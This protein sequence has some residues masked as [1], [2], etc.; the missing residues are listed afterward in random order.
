AIRRVLDWLRS[1]GLVSSDGPGAV[2]HRIVHGAD[3]FDQSVLIDDEVMKIIE[4][5]GDLA[6]LHN[7]PSLAAIRAAQEALGSSVPMVGVFDTAFHQTIPDHAA[8]YAIPKE[9]TDKYGIRRYGFHGT[10]HRYMTERYAAITDIPVEQARLV[11]L[12]LGNGCSATAV[13]EGC[14]VDTSMG[15]T[16]LEGLIMGTRSGSVDPSLVAFL[17]QHEK[18]DVAEVEN[19]L[20]KESGLLGVSGVSQAMRELLEAEARG[21][22]R[23]ALALKMFCYRVRTYI[24]TYLAVVGGADAV[25]FGGGIGENAPQMRARICADMDWCGLTLDQQLNNDTTGSEGRISTKDSRTQAYV[26]AVD[27]EVM[28]VQ[29]TVNCLRHN[30]QRRGK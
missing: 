5:L 14:S 15:F 12:Q 6:P 21:D 25:V 23:A 24:G 11:T 19:W 16:P 9:L 27:E 7:R 8:Q 2:G 22:G 3:Y 26:V 13:K 17:A 18:V 20:N 28:I 1:T 4:E 10:A 29:D 30:E